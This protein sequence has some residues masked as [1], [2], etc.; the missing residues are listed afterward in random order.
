MFYQFDK[1]L[2]QSELQAKAVEDMTNKVNDYKNFIER[3]LSE[4]KC[5]TFSLFIRLTVCLNCQSS[6]YNYVLFVFFKYQ[7]TSKAS[8]QIKQ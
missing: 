3:K 8:K 7:M 2:V 4:N 5:K 6:K 1:K